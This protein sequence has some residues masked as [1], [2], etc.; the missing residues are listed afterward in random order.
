M[1][2]GGA[3]S[4]E[5]L[6]LLASVLDHHCSARD[7]KT[8]PEREDVARRLLSLF[9][10]ELSSAESLLGIMNDPSRPKADA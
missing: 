10:T 5:Q 2:F 6:D 4:P 8:A 9:H 7:I 1:H 3:F